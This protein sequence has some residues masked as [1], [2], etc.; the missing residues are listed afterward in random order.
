VTASEELPEGKVS[1]DKLGS[2]MDEH[3]TSPSL[4]TPRVKEGMHTVSH[5]RSQ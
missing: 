3:V 1:P 2:V 5:K 4:K